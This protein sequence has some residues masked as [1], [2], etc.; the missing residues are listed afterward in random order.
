MGLTVGRGAT[1]GRAEIS[2]GGAAVVDDAD[3]EHGMGVKDMYD[4]NV[5]R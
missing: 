3:I 1:P 5:A 4:D 2:D